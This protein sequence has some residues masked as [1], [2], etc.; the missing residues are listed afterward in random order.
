[1][2]EQRKREVNRNAMRRWR[3]KHPG[4]DTHNR[5]GITPED[6]QALLEA[7]GHHCAICGEAN[8]V[9]DL[10]QLRSRQLNVDHDHN[11]GKI[12]GLLCHHCNVG[13]GHFKDNADLLRK[14]LAYLA[15]NQ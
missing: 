13:L 15:I 7:Q 4:R 10:N 8:Q 6:F 1:M 2:T 3:A 14:A 11:T 5:H 12:R 9:H